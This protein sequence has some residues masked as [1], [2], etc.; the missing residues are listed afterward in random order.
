MTAPSPASALTGSPV[1]DLR[2]FFRAVGNPLFG[3]GLNAEPPERRETTIPVEMLDDPDRVKVTADPM[4]VA[5]FVDGVQSSLV[6]THREHRPVYLCYQAAG[7]VGPGALLVGMKERLTI[8]CSVADRDWVDE[9]NTTPAIPVSELPDVVP[10][11]VERAAY[12]QLGD[13]RERLER[14]LVEELVDAGQTPLVVDG[15]L[16]ARPFSSHLCGV[17]KDAVHTRYLADES[18]LYGLP[19]GW[20]S[21]R[22]KLPAKTDGCRFDRFSCYLRLHDARQFGWAHGLIRLESYDPAHLDALAA[23]AMAERQSSRS[24]DGR[25]DRHLASVA[26]TEKVLR[27]RRPTVFNF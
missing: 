13:W 7:A 18:I 8:V 4:D 2:T 1:Y 22:F 24:G 15:S 10:P 12:A 11:E 3:P 20:R 21:A 27:S 9:V 26:T 6:V 14:S 25:W 17:V 19:A 16:L 5:A 23:R